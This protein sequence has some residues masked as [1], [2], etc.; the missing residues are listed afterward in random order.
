MN[1]LFLVVILMVNLT[2]LDNSISGPQLDQIGNTLVYAMPYDFSEYSVYTSNSYASAQWQSAIVNGLYK[3]STSTHLAWAPDLAV[4]MPAI[5][6][7]KK[8]FTVDLKSDLVFSN[9]DP[10]TADDV[11]F[12]FKVA[13]TPAINTNFYVGFIGFMN[14]D[15][16][17]KID[18]TRIQITLLQ[19]FAFP[20]SFL[21]TPLIPEET[22]RDLRFMYF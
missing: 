10:L 19:A 14:N 17:L 6:A 20:F 21:S 12:S 11:V 22:W 3:R 16:V 1:Y 4:A 9:G 8:R 7:D 13:I 5:S 18:N 2:P 15:S